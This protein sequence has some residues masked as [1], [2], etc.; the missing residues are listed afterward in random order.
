MEQEILNDEK[1]S[2]YELILEEY[3]ILEKYQD[4]LILKIEKQ[5]TI[6]T[7]VWAI[8]PFLKFIKNKSINE[9][10]K[11]DVE[12]YYRS[13]IKLKKKTNTI[14]RYLIELRYFLK[15]YKP[16]NNFFE[17]IKIKKDKSKLPTDA[18]LTKDEA[19]KVLM[20]AR[21]YRDRALI[22]LLWDSAARLSEILNLKKCDIQFDQYGGTIRVDG[23][24][25]DRII[26]LTDS[27]PDVQELVNRH[28]GSINDFL[29]CSPDGKQLTAHGAQNIVGRAAKRSGIDKNVHPHIFRHSKLTYL[30]KHGMMEMELR[31][32]AGWSNDSDMPA[33]YLHLSGADIEDR[34]LQIAGI[35]K[36]EKVEEVNTSIKTCPRCHTLNSFDTVYCRNCSMILDQTR[37]NPV[38]P[39]IEKIQKDMEIKMIEIEMNAY[40][41]PDKMKV[42]DLQYKIGTL[43]KYIRSGKRPD[44]RIL[45]KH[46]F[47]NLSPEELELYKN[48]IAEAKEELEE[49][50]H[51]IQE[52]TSDYQKQIDE[53]KGK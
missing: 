46:E 20:Q 3:D 10:T 53:L 27:V 34:V 2:K 36:I 7:K 13:L 4:K 8:V 19:M 30:A 22:F 9:V 29:F 23:K 33:T 52:L 44:E 15:I 24:T 6:Q 50:K 32:F 31:I 37:A 35:K 42:K 47:I 11:D 40:I 5:T 45:H 48:E 28:T 38:N 16:I 17:D 43:R 14:R 49:L 26:R 39:E 41:R 18:I 12:G 51:G 25:E 21:N 1:K